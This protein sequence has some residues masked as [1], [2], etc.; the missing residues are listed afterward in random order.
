MSPKRRR[1][2]SNA[3]PDAATFVEDCYQ[4]LLGRSADSAGLDTYVHLLDGGAPR[5][6]VVMSL[7][8]GEEYKQRILARASPRRRNSDHYRLAIDVSGTSPF[9]AFD[10]RD[11]S[12]FD[13]LEAAIIEDGYYEHAGVWTLEP[14]DDKRIMGRILAGLGPR[15]ALE[16]GCSSG[17]VLEILTEHGVDAEGVEISHLSRTRRLVPKCGVEFISATCRA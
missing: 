13:W 5:T 17:T 4:R 12:D 14:D 11:P 3:T 1:F 2:V 16:L 9:V 8:T 6:E 15:R 10:V 7:A